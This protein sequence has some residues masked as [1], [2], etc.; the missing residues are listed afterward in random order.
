MKD[1]SNQALIIFVIAV[2]RTNIMT[3]LFTC[4]N[5]YHLFGWIEIINSSPSVF[6]TPVK[7]LK[8]SNRRQAYHTYV[9]KKYKIK[10]WLC[11]QTWMEK[12]C[13][14]ISS[15]S[16]G[17]CYAVKKINTKGIVLSQNSRV[18]CVGFFRYGKQSWGHWIDHLIYAA[19]VLRNSVWSHFACLQLQFQTA[20]QRWWSYFSCTHEP[21]ANAY[22]WNS[23]C[24]SVARNNA[25][26]SYTPTWRHTFHHFWALTHISVLSSE[27]EHGLQHQNTT[28]LG[29]H[30][31]K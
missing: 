30:S 28:A 12:C 4:C 6:S 25:I 10:A 8:L 16:E 18:I 5:F 13:L 1:Y 27:N 22:W 15:T 31:W 2:R 20:S 3:Q 24:Y 17:G 21:F 7:T 26:V 11:W 14:W 19:N 29:E 9:L 23:V